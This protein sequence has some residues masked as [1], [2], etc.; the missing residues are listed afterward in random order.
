MGFLRMKAA[1]EW[2]KSPEEFEALSE[3]DQAWMMG[4]TRVNMR[5]AAWETDEQQREWDRKRK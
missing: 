5:M 3:D 1:K 2:G 4:F